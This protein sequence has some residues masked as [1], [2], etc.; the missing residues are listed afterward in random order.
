LSE[1]INIEKIDRT[2]MTLGVNNKN[3]KMTRK[4]DTYE[5][6]TLAE[7]IRSDQVPA[8]ELA[9]IFT[10]KTYYNWYKKKYLNKYK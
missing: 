1:N 2:I 3:N 4:V 6:E 8:S 5:Y 9:E 7:C 10:D